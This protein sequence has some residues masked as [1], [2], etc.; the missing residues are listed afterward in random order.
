MR[1]YSKVYPQ[2]GAK[3]KYPGWRFSKCQT[4]V[5]SDWQ[6]N[7]PV[8]R[9][10]PRATIWYIERFRWIIWREVIAVRNSNFYSFWKLPRRW[11][12]L[13]HNGSLGS[14]KLIIC[15][16]YFVQNAESPDFVAL[17]VPYIIL[18]EVSYLKL[19]VWACSNLQYCTVMNNQ[20]RR[21]GS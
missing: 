19:V 21:Y 13:L 9:L 16:E 2:V 10:A 5:L 15:P 6:K 7:A 3:Y 12:L 8:V 4:R 20:T 11:K 1:A 17:G 14:L 18:G